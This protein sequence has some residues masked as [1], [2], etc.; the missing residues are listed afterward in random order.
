MFRIALIWALLALPAATQSP[1]G[2]EAACAIDEGD[3]HVM[4]PPEWDG[5]APMPALIWYHGHN[6]SAASV[7]RSRGLIDTFVKNGYALIAPNGARL[8]G[9]NTRAWPARRDGRDRRDDVAFTLSVLDDAKSRF[10]I[11]EARIFVAGFSA[12]GSMAWLMACEAASHFAG[13]ASVS[14]A[15][16]RPVPETECTDGPFRLLQVHGFTDKQVPFEGRGIR[17]WHQGDLFE[18]F[19]LARATNSCRSNPDD[20][21]ING[22]FR[23]RSWGASCGEGALRMCIHDGGHGLPR[24]WTDL[25]RD[26]FETD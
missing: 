20:I 11:D 25:A 23:C 7:F 17:D 3:Y 18:S 14:G 5:E 8:P 4:L 16:R 21:A 2:P 15:L 24:G 1:C 13:F 9:R 26:F 22:A 19:G 10:A 6:S 12:G